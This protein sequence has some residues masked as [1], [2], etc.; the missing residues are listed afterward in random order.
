MRVSILAAMTL[1]VL[2]RSG[3]AQDRGLDDPLKPLPK[4]PLTRQEL[5]R[6]AS[7]PKCAEGLRRERAEQFTEALK[8]YQEAA[9]LDP[10]SSAVI[11]VQIPILLGMERV[12]D[13]V[14][15]CKKVVALDPG[16][17]KTWFLLGKLHKSSARYVD[18]IAAL[19]S[20]SKSVALKKHPEAAQGIYFELGALYESAEKFGPAADAYNKAAEILEHP[21]AIMAKGDFPRALILARAADT[22]EKIGQLYRKAKHY[23]D[24][25]AH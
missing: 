4:R 20:A 9:R 3:S 17:Y 25:V 2:V 7:E 6:R 14:D 5:D 16:D 15:A 12:S 1:L 21:D 18:A 8:A 19:E 24:A 23:D 22:Y 13:A 10:N 11:K